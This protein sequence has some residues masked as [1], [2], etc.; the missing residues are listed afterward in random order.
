MHSLLNTSRPPLYCPGCSHDR[1]TQVLDRSLQDLELS[2]HQVAIVS[3][4]GCNG[5]FDTFF[6]THALHGLHGRALTYAT[7]IK[8]ARPEMTVIVTMGDGGMGIG[9]AHFNAACRRNVDLTLLVLNNFNFGMTGGQY[10]ATTPSEAMVSTGFLNRLEPPLD[11]CEIARS[12]GATFVKRVSVFDENLT[13]VIAA[14]ITHAGTSVLD[15]WGVC[16]GRYTKRNKVSPKSI[17]EQIERLPNPDGIIQNNARPEYGSAYRQAAGEAKQWSRPL[18][19][20]KTFDPPAPGRQEIIILGNAGQRVV[21]AGELL[22]YAGMSAGMQ[23]TKKDEYNI[24]VLRGPS[25]SEVILSPDEID[26][27]GIRKPSVIIAIAQESVDRRSRI[28]ETL[29]PE[30]VLIC[31]TDVTVPAT[32]ASVTMIDFQQMKVKLV[33]RALATLAI[34]AWQAKAI[35]IDMLRYALEARFSSRSVE[36]SW[37]LVI[38]MKDRVVNN[39]R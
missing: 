26:Y 17:S 21:T 18:R 14:A 30:T 24:T 11:I 5:Q 36:T 15:I 29:R 4:I 34:L 16:P 31:A 33:D 12:C 19:I 28:F 22:C 13:G 39:N 6:N 8:L 25:I 9:G 3:D 38:R 2:G 27:T 23:V 37:E 7:G 10:S 32:D 35:T 20:A 1:M